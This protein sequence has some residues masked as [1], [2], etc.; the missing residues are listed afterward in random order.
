MK[1]LITTTILLMEVCLPEFEK[2]QEA[3]LKWGT[4]T[5]NTC[6]ARTHTYTTQRCG[7]KEAVIFRAKQAS[8]QM[9]GLVE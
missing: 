9:D 8:L 2:G 3:F 5:H 4:Q 1:K 6:V 7:L